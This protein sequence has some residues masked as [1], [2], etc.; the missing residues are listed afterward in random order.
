[1]NALFR[2][3]DIAP[4]VFFRVVFG[5]LGFADVIGI[6]IYHHLYQG[7]F[8]P[9]GFQFKYMGFEWVPVMPEPFMSL[10]FLITAAA[11]IFILLGK[12]YRSSTLVFAIGFTWIFLLEKA[13][14]LNHRYLFCWISWVMVFL[15]ANRQWSFDVV[16]KPSLESDTIQGWCLWVLPF[17]MGV[18]YFYGGIAKINSD[19]LRGMPL[20][21]WLKEAE[22]MPVL[23]TIWKLEMTPPIM[24][25]AGLLLDLMAPFFLLFTRKRKWVFG[26]ILF[27]HLIN[28]L[29]FSIGIFP[30]L[31]ISLSLLFF[32]PSKFR[33]WF[34]RLMQRFKKLRP[35][36]LW[37]SR[38]RPNSTSSSPVTPPAYPRWLVLS[39]LF[40]LILIHLFVPL[41]H[42]LLSDDVTWTEKGH[43]YSWRMLLRSKR[44]SGTFTVANLDTGEITI[45]RPSEYL[46]GRQS[47]KAITRPDMIWQFAGHL[48]E[49]WK[50]KGEENVAVFADLKVR[51]NGRRAQQFTNSRIDLTKE[52]WH[53]F[54]AEKWILPFER[55]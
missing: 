32:P 47:R 22:D 31:S 16:R 33:R 15:P 42:H 54:G 36:E 49:I 4:L 14:Y 43:R 48:E 8:D 23:G 39:L 44:G 1:M 37:W 7:N 24:A 19:W 9:A 51:L 34:S 10:L 26:L 52:D 41:R 17:L 3:V 28:F 18:V 45:V 25:W 13:V 20:D 38:L 30:W 5:V 35:L 40:P 53:H 6:W 55:E 46:S 12:S 2:P 50:A 11:S 29:I 27:F 21:L